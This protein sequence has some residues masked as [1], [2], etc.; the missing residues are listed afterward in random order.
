MGSLVVNRGVFTT[1][2]IIPS[3]K[4]CFVLLLAQSFK[5]CAFVTISSQTVQLLC[6][7]EKKLAAEMEYVGYPND[8]VMGL[9]GKVGCRYCTEHVICFT[10]TTKTLTSKQE[11]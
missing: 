9:L 1:R 8:T 11:D 10:D 5:N 4:F 7:A 6:P 3:P 2:E